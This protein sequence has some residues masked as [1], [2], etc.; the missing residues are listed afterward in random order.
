[1]PPIQPEERIASLETGQRQIEN[2]IHSLATEFRTFA[3]E[4][5][6]IILASNKPQWS[7]IISGV[8]LVVTIGTLAFAPLVYNMQRMDNDAT[9]HRRLGGHPEL[10]E[11]VDA[12]RREAAFRDI[13]LCERLNIATQA[14]M[15]CAIFGPIR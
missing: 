3:S 5:R 9:Y 6:N 1:M 8:A 12:S 14:H 13:A 10:D 2:D 15:D 7:P 4:V 11:R